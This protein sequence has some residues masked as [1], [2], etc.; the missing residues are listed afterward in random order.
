MSSLDIRKIEKQKWRLNDFRAWLSNPHSNSEENEYFDLKEIFY[1][2]QKECR[3][4]FASFANCEGGF[5]VFGV[6]DESREIVG[7]DEFDINLRI[8]NILAPNCINPELNWGIA[9]EF[10]FKK[11]RS[12][13][14]VYVVKIEKTVPFWRRPHISDGVVY[15]RRKGK[16]EP[17]KTLLDLRQRF[18]Q[19][20][21]FIPEDL[22]YID[23]T[24]RAFKENNYS[25]DILDVF[26][27]RLWAGIK[28][29][30]IDSAIVEQDKYQDDR[31]EL[32]SLY[33]EIS[34]YIEKA[35]RKKSEASTSTGL[36]DSFNAGDE[37]LEQVYEKIAGR[38]L[39]FKNKFGKYLKTMI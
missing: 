17:I 9:K 35:K 6:K 1:A 26:I 30:I 3:K 10:K 11:N 38:L 25:I 22:I 15:V 4:D 7:V 12:F 34:E 39:I 2:S 23:E 37:E 19:K 13:R 8:E 20:N 21:D 5:I 18:F 14:F 31:K 33:M 28:H 32:L 29:Y 16:S 24:I 27:I 36:P